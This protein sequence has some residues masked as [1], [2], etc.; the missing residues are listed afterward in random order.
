MTYSFNDKNLK[1]VKSNM[2]PQEFISNNPKLTLQYIIDI[3]EFNEVFDNK[4][5]ENESEQ[6][7]GFYI[8]GSIARYEIFILK[9]DGEFIGILGSEKI[10]DFPHIHFLD[11]GTKFTWYIKDE[12]KICQVGYD[13]TYCNHYTFDGNILEF[14]NAEIMHKIKLND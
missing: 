6:I 7:P 11:E 13:E 10:T 2:T 8:R 3:D 14:K 12:N 1:S 4:K 5:L 9:P